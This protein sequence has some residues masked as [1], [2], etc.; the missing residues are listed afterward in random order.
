MPGKSA[1]PGFS[2]TFFKAMSHLFDNLLSNEDGGR[3]VVNLLSR[4]AAEIPVNVSLSPLPGN[5]DG[6]VICTVV[7]RPAPAA[8]NEL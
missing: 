8:T 7:H 6:R 4:T 1:G 5:T 2:N 3:A